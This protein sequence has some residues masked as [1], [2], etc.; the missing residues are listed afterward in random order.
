MKKTSLLIL[1]LLVS[2]YSFSQ[3][4]QFG[5]RVGISSSQISINDDLE[6]VAYRY[7]SGN[8]AV[9]FH[10]GLYSRVSLLGFYIQPEVLFTSS[11]GEVEV[12]STTDPG[13]VIKEYSFNKLD[14]P[15]L[16]GKKFVNVFRFELGPTFSYLL[17]EEVT[18]VSGNIEDVK[19][20]YN[21]ATIGYQVGLGLDI[22]KIIIDLK[23]EGNLSKLGN[24]ITIGGD[25]FNTDLRNN[26][27]I[28]SLGF[29][30]L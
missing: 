3:S 20:N 28:L 2:S 12:T 11:G 7:E 14:V 24:E 27:F 10:V 13:E 29:N 4:L 17:N 23:Y 6:D 19:Q 18:D 21:N 16:I 1:F 9:G 22:G 15:V 30:L 5:P 26:Q 25:S 8:A